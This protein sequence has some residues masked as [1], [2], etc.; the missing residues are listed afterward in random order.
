M[1][2][3]KEKKTRKLTFMGAFH[4]LLYRY[5]APWRVQ[6]QE[7]ADRPW[8]SSLLWYYLRNGH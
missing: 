3:Q 2:I 4:F 6:I 8:H 7:R 1:H 5:I